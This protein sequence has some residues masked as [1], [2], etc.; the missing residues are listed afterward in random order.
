MFAEYKLT[1]D[2]IVALFGGDRRVGGLEPAD[3]AALREA[4]TR[5]WG[6]LRVLNA[7]TRTKTVFRYGFESGKLDRPPRYGRGSSPPPGPCY[8][9]TRPRPRRGRPRPPTCGSW[10]TRPGRR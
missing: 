7:V 4:M 10:S 5:R 3:F 1:T 2:M 9:G 8:G 6:P